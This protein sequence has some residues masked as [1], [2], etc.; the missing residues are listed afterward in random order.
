MC[1]ENFYLPTTRLC[2]KR[3]HQYIYPVTTRVHAMGEDI[4]R[5]ITCNNKYDGCHFL[6]GELVIYKF[7]YPLYCT[8]ETFVIRL[9]FGLAEQTTLL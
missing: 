1:H 7:L 3:I 2:T 9:W 8:L 6:Y 4:I 5:P